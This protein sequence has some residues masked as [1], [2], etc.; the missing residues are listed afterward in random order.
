MDLKEAQ[1]VPR[2]KR[3]VMVLPPPNVT[4]SLHLGHALMGAIEDTI[5]RYKRLKGYVS[6][7]V[8]GTDHA[9]IATQSVVEKKILK[10]E[11]KYRTDFSRE[12]FVKRVWEWKEE[13]GNRIMEQF[14]KLGVSFDLS[15][16]YFTMD[17]ERSKSVQEAFVQLFDRGILYRAKRM[18]NWCCA[19]QTAI[20]DVELEDFEIPQ[21]TKI[22]IPKHKGTYE[23]GVLIDFAYKLKK[24]PSKEIIVSTTR[25]ETMLGDT[26]VAV[27]PDDDRYKMIDI[28]I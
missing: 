2:D 15:R 21:P 27:H 4:G 22:S 25:I 14:D 8:P 26:A 16:Q 6:L 12:E 19:L 20:S 5:T 3:F 10:S 11:G 18:V 28:K 7:W 1:K 23:F 9:G 24:D 13:Y 17:E